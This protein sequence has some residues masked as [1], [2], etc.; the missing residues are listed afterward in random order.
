MLKARRHHLPRRLRL[1]SEELP[2]VLLVAELRLRLVVVLDRRVAL[3]RLA[4]LVLHAFEGA[5]ER[6]QLLPKLRHHLLRLGGR[7]ERRRSKGFR[8]NIVHVL[9]RE[10]LAGV[11]GLGSHLIHRRVMRRGHRRLPHRLGASWLVLSDVRERGRVCL[12]L[13]LVAGVLQVAPLRVGHLL[14]RQLPPLRRHLGLVVVP[15]VKALGRVRRP[16]GLE[17]RRVVEEGVVVVGRPLPRAPERP[18]CYRLVAGGAVRVH[19]L[20]DHRLGDNGL[21][22]VLR[23]DVHDLLLG[24]ALLVFELLQRDFLARLRGV[25]R[26]LL[27]Q[28]AVR[29]L[30]QLPLPVEELAGLALVLVRQRLVL[31]ERRPLRLGSGRSVACS[32]L[33]RVLH[34]RLCTRLLGCLVRMRL[35]ALRL[36][37]SVL[38]PVQQ[39][40]QLPLQLR[41]AALRGDGLRAEGGRHGRRLPRPSS[42]CGRSARELLERHARRGARRCVRESGPLAGAFEERDP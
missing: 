27:F 32:F 28:R 35:D 2:R 19:R 31:Q 6:R 24:H 34:R 20:L 7:F 42:V 10:D 37:V 41:G 17:H 9:V 11:G 29:L 36:M 30:E 39:P 21:G 26:H 8:Q 23:L 33:H 40:M 14:S 15:A 3:Q 22:G 5:L 13:R 38:L 16:V 18:R 12:R 4:Q 1:L 25:Q